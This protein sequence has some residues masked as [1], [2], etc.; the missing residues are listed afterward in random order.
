MLSLGLPPLTHAELD[1][2]DQPGSGND[3]PSFQ[4]SIWWWIHTEMSGKLFECMMI[5]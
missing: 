5:V 2:Q 3:E 1:E 4:P